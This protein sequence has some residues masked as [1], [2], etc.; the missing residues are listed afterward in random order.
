MA[1]SSSFLYLV[2]INFFKVNNGNTRII[3][4]I[5]SKLPIK[6]SE[7]CNWCRSGVVIVDFV[8]MTL[9]SLNQ[10]Q[11]CL[12][13]EI[14]RTRHPCS[15]LCIVEV[16]VHYLSIQCFI[17]FCTFP[18]FDTWNFSPLINWLR[19][20]P[21]NIRLG[22]DVLET[23]WRLHQC[24]NCSSS[25]TSWRR[26]EDVFKTFGR[27][28]VVALYCDKNRQSLCDLIRFW[29]CSASLQRQRLLIYS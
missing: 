13:T 6:T 20:L 12:A 24:K 10:N 7:S 1:Q 22:E 4:E 14:V 3:C 23:S 25:K 27:R 17:C 29:L 2:S 11:R 16:L 9:F 8:S 15:S 26:L 5:C 28:K 19:I 21:T 18:V